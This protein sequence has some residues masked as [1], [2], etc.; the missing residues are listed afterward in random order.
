MRAWCITDGK[1]GNVAQAQAL[2]EALGAELEMHTVQVT[3]P[4]RLLPNRF[5]DLGLARLLP[6][7]KKKPSSVQPDLIISCGRKGALASASLRT[8]APRIHIQDPQMSCKPFDLIIAMAHDKVR[9]ANVIKTPYALHHITE[10]KLAAARAHWEPKF[11]HLPRPWNAIL[12]GGSTNKYLFSAEAMQI[13]IAEIDALPGSLLITTSRRTG[14]ENITLL[15][16]HFGGHNDRVFL[17]TGELE[18]PYLGMLACAD[19]LFVTNDSVNM[20]SEAIASGK[21]VTIMPLV[22]HAHTKPSRFAET[23]KELKITPQ[24]MMEEVVASVRQVL[25]ARA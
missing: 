20:I 9:G 25:T 10:A 12:I 2:A 7:L 8:R 3:A 24:E 17:Y 14:E 4:W 16:T 1:A 11:A 13:L 23:V 19:H 6:V 22:G 15:T 5:H 21:P 18:N